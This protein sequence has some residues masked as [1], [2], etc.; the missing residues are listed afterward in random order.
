MRV[1]L[2]GEGIELAL[3]NV[4]FDLLIPGVRDETLNHCVKAAKSGFANRV[5]SDSNS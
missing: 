5:T 1:G 2:L 4:G 3:G